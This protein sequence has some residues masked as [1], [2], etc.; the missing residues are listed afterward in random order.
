KVFRTGKVIKV[1]FKEQKVLVEGVNIAIKH[2]TSADDNDKKKLKIV[3]QKVV[4]FIRYKFGLA[5]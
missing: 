3:L 1:F 2:K 5:F 4:I